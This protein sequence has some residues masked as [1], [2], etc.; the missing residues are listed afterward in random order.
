MLSFSLKSGHPLA[1]WWP[2]LV[3]LSVCVLLRFLP[4]GNLWI[5]GSTWA[6]EEPNYHLQVIWSLLASSPFVHGATDPV[7]SWLNLIKDV[8]FLCDNMVALFRLS[9][10]TNGVC[11]YPNENGQLREQRHSHTWC[12]SLNIFSFHQC[13]RASKEL[14]FNRSTFVGCFRQLMWPKIERLVHSVTIFCGHTLHWV[15]RK[16]VDTWTSIGLAVC[17]HL[18]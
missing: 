9:T 17:K 16:V 4:Y 11:K 10:F 8:P 2:H 12:W 18:K 15:C 5:L 7:G 1:E 3:D 6:N 13:L 14:P